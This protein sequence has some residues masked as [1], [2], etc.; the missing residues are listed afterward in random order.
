M[1]V[2]L[3][4]L[5]RESCSRLRQLVQSVT[6]NLGPTIEAARQFLAQMQVCMNKE[7]TCVELSQCML[8]NSPRKIALNFCGSQVAQTHK[9]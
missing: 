8:K 4:P 7:K 6:D 9:H 3:K 5:D 1:G 2:D